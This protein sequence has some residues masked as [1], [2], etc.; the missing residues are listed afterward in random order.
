PNFTDNSLPTAEEIGIALGNELTAPSFT[1]STED[2]APYLVYAERAKPDGLN[3]TRIDLEK[4]NGELK[5]PDRVLALSSGSGVYRPK[6]GDFVLEDGV[7]VSTSDGYALTG[8]KMI[9]DLKSKRVES[10]G[11]V[12]AESPEGE[13]Q[14]GAMTVEAGS[15]EAGGLVVLFEGGVRL[16]LRPGTRAVARPARE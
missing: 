5:L 4:I 8:D 14:A 2:G 16:R 12:Q 11:P 15:A 3:P 6:D 7:R 9:A 13:L 1:G 10:V